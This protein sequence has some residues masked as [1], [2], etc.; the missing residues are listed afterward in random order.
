MLH[1]ILEWFQLK[2]TFDHVVTMSPAEIP[3]TSAESPIQIGLK[4]FEYFQ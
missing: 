3:S 4:H 2:G 1:R